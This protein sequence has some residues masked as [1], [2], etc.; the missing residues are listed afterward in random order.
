MTAA[1]NEEYVCP[2]CDGNSFD[3]G[4]CICSNG[5]GVFHVA[6]FGT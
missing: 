3:K 2:I 5:R 6:L 4:S 1:N